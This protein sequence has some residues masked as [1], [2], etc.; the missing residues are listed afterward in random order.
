MKRTN[1]LS[2]VLVCLI[3]ISLVVFSKVIC[4]D[5][6]YTLD[7]LCNT[8]GSF[9]YDELLVDIL[10]RAGIF[11]EQKDSSFS[12]APIMAFLER[13]EKSPPLPSGICLS[14]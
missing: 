14:G 12:P 4:E 5:E 2:S 6:D 3:A 1:F 9:Y 8:N 7:M 10:S 11:Y 13:Q